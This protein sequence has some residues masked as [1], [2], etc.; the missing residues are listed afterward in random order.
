MTLTA[1]TANPRIK[2]VMDNLMKYLHIWAKEVDLSIE[3]WL[4]AC[5]V[6]RS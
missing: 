3:E 2:Y 4:A 1:F 5:D 6:V